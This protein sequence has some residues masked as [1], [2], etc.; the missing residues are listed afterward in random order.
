ME[1]FDAT[2]RGNRTAGTCRQL[3]LRGGDAHW[4]ALQ[5]GGEE[6]MEGQLPALH[7]AWRKGPE[8]PVLD[9]N[10]GF[11]DDAAIESVRWDGYT[12]RLLIRTAASLTRPVHFLDEVLEVFTQDG[13]RLAVLRRAHEGAQHMRWECHT[14][15]PAAQEIQGDHIEL[16]YTVLW[17]DQNSGGLCG[18]RHSRDTFLGLRDG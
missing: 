7:H 18:L 8:L 12:N 3:D 11:M 9:K 6:R 2:Y 13:T 1:S 4:F 5:Y 14:T 17:A 10:A 15:L 16:D